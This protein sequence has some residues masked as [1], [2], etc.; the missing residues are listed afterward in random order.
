MLQV[1]AK[2]YETAWVLA[3]L[4][5]GSRRHLLTQPLGRQS[6]PVQRKHDRWQL[7]ARLV[8]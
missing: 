7:L 5:T 8:S 6:Y 1:I 3:L 4:A 2:E